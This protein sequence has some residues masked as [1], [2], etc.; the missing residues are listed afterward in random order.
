M[1]SANIF[2]TEN[3]AVKSYGNGTFYLFVNKKDNL[4]V[5]LQGDSAAEF[6]AQWTALL[7][8]KGHWTI[9]AIFAELFSYYAEIAT[10]GEPK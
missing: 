5:F 10:P 9:D 3:Y 4:E 7:D 8:T 6:N 1:Q 2:R